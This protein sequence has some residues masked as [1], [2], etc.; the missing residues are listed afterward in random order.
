[1]EDRCPIYVVASKC[2][3]AQT[4]MLPSL[5]TAQPPLLR[6]AWVSLVMEQIQTDR[7]WEWELGQSVKFSLS[8][9][10]FDP[11]IGRESAL[12]CLLDVTACLTC[13]LPQQHH[14]NLSVKTQFRGQQLSK[15]LSKWKGTEGENLLLFL[16]LENVAPENYVI[17]FHKLVLFGETG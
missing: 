14:K 5:N 13:Q 10:G 17:K 15:C 11:V 6:K 3:H 8:K 9:S 4:P 12:C 2:S 16:A 1:M 7:Y